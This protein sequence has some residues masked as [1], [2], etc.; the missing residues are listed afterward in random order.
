MS[1]RAVIAN[2]G[3]PT[4]PSQADVKQFLGEFLTD[5]YVINLPG[6]IRHL[7]VKGVIAPL[8]SKR[9]S[10]AYQSIWSSEGGPLRFYTEAIAQELRDKGVSAVAGMRYGEPSLRKAIE[11]QPYS[12]HIVLVPLYPQYADS[13]IT[14]MVQHA[15]QFVGDR[16]LSVVPPFFSRTEYIDALITHTRE[17]LHSDIEHLVISFHS[18][19]VRHI[20]NADPTKTHCLKIEDCCN[21]KSTSHATCYRHQS[22]ETSNS[23]GQ[24]LG[25]PFTVSFQSRLGKLKWLE[26]STVATVAKLASAGIQKIAVV[27]P[28]FTVDNLETLEEIGIQARELFVSLG[29]KKLQLISSLNTNPSWIQFLIKLID[30]QTSKLH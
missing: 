15:L 7:L 27:C 8:R 28:A 3:S 19:P 25:L 10:R 5:P 23:L 30:E 26:P 11:S 20:T 1:V 21:V 13:T 22:L 2:L 17:E 18:L 9:S 4:S 12:K 24:N 14:T 6:P 29:G 16:K